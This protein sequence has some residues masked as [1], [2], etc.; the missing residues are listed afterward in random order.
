MRQAGWS[1]LRFHHDAD[2]AELV[3]SRSD[4]FGPGRQ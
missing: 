2:W 4:A 1:V 3:A